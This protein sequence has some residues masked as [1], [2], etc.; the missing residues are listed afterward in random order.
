MPMFPISSPLSSPGAATAVRQDMGS[1]ST[2]ALHKE[3]AAAII[4]T[5]IQANSTDNGIAKQCSVGRRISRSF[6]TA[7]HNSG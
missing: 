4:R 5:L 6:C 1:T 7:L 3:T 2:S